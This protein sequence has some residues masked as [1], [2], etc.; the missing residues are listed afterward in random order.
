MAQSFPINS[1][2]TFTEI[3]DKCGLS[4][5]TTRRILR[6][7]MTNHIFQES[8]PGIVQH[9]VASKV[10]ADFSMNQWIGMVTG[11]GWPAAANTVLAL[12]KWQN[13]EEPNETV[14]HDGYI[15]E[16]SI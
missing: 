16:G 14:C 1:K 10:L 2:A 6:H 12:K 5:P 13:S 15:F 11:E 3:S 7:G 8:S 4:E 9:T